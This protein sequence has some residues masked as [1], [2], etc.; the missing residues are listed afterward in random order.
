[1]TSGRL[2]IRGTLDNWLGDAIVAF[3]AR[4]HPIDTA[5]ALDSVRLPGLA[6]RDPADRFLIGTAR[7]LGAQLVTADAK[8]LA[9]GAT[10]HVAVI[11]PRS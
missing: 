5:I 7:R 1:M 3:G 4:V 2:T 9:Y 10:G 11:D 6:H 8:I